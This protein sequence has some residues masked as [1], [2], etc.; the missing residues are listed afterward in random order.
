MKDPATNS[1]LKKKKKKKPSPLC[2]FYE[3]LCGWEKPKNNLCNTFERQLIP[4][5]H[6]L[7]W[8]MLFLFFFFLLNLPV[9]GRMCVHCH[10]SVYMWT[11]SQWT[12]KVLMSGWERWKLRHNI[13]RRLLWN[14]PRPAPAALQQPAHRQATEQLLF[15]PSAHLLFLISP[16]SSREN[17]S[18]I[19]AMMQRWKRTEEHVQT[20]ICLVD[21]LSSPVWFK[22]VM[23]VLIS[24][25]KRPSYIRQ[26]ADQ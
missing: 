8:V 2:L 19:R 1:V 23:M 24:Q 14:S 25:C 13:Q 15:T 22:W 16:D 6:L 21:S 17:Y 20:A 7:L 9:Y 12:G 26:L 5:P 10:G 11:A 3:A 4:Q 18:F